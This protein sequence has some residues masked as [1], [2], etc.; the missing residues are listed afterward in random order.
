MEMASKHL[1]FVAKVLYAEK[2]GE[3]LSDVTMSR[4]HEVCGLSR[5]TVVNWKISNVVPQN[6][7]IDQLCLATGVSKE[8]VDAVMS[9]PLDIEIN[10]NDFYTAIKN[11]D[12]PYIK[13]LGFSPN[14]L[15]SQLIAAIEAL[16]PDHLVKKL[17]AYRNKGD[18]YLPPVDRFIFFAGSARILYKDFISWIESSPKDVKISIDYLTSIMDNLE[19]P[20]QERGL[21]FMRPDRIDKNLR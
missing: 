20:V 10:E 7:K 8:F 11:R 5:Q 12:I 16:S 2:T 1:Y 4:I 18:D 21:F 14:F 3:E 17:W 19:I 9:L 13:R 15:P 6:S